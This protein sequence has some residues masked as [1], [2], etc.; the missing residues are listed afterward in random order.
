MA[1]T[2]TP[3]PAAKKSPTGSPK[4]PKWLYLA[5]TTTP[6]SFKNVFPGQVFRKRANRR[7]APA[8]ALQTLFLTC[9]FEPV[10]GAM[11]ARR[12]S[13]IG[14][15]NTYAK[16]LYFV[17][18]GVV[19]GAQGGPKGSPG[20]HFAIT[21]DTFCMTW[22][23]DLSRL[24]QTSRFNRKA[25]LQTIE[26]NSFEAKVILLVPKSSNLQINKLSSVK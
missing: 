14:V 26:I 3:I 12:P 9:N 21:F 2:T 10:S 24:V 20:N 5:P 18:F 11:R 25:I 1:L 8:G 19:L 22:A 6:K 4:S 13:E 17:R 16:Y 7:S 15:Q 23:D